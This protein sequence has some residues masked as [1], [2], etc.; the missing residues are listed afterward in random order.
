MQMR[1]V[2]LV[3]DALLTTLASLVSLQDFTLYA[4]SNGRLLLVIPCLQDSTVLT[5]Y[6]KGLPSTV[7]RCQPGASRPSRNILKRKSFY[8]NLKEDWPNLYRQGQGDGDSELWS[9]EW[10]QHGICSD[11]QNDPLRYFKCVIDLF[12]DRR[13]RNLR[14]DV[15]IE[16]G[17]SYTSEEIQKKLKG[18]YGANP[19]IAC[20]VLEIRFCY[21]R[22]QGRQPVDL[23]DCPKLSD[24]KYECDKSK[25]QRPPAPALRVVIS[26]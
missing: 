25:V 17:K 3:G 9:I 10:N 13:F 12:N 19:Q 24:R 18:K 23:E 4:L 2:S 22:V 1:Q 14:Q 5:T 11:L 6:P 26:D 16:V 21:K 15:G 7:Y 20:K 8:T